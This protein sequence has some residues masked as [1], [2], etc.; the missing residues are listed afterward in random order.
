MHIR[1]LILAFV[2]IGIFAP[3]LSRAD[4]DNTSPPSGYVWCDLVKLGGSVL[5]P[6]GWFCSEITIPTGFGYRI[7]KE[8]V[9]S[10]SA[11]HQTGFTIKDSN[12]AYW[13]MNRLTSADFQTGFT[14]KALYGPFWDKSRLS[15]LAG[16]I[17]EDSKREGRVSAFLVG[18]IGRYTTSNFNMETVV[19]YRNIIESQHYV[20]LILQDTEKPT[21]VRVTFD[22]PLRAWPQNEAYSKTFFA[23]LSLFQSADELNHSPYPA[24]ASVS[25]AA[26]QP[27]H[28]P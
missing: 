28:Q 3:Y 23:T 25:T 6:K 2:C 12:Q 16:G 20:E 22:C 4:G 5:I 19:T 8:E 13:D 11:G 9:V 26:E 10:K 17:I 14:I 1:P 27:Q 15:K 24:L 21:F 18:S 7:T